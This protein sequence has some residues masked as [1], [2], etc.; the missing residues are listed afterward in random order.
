MSTAHATPGTV[1]SMP[2]KMDCPRRA[3]SKDFSNSLLCIQSATCPTTWT[4]RGDPAVTRQKKHTSSLNTEFPCP[5]MTRATC[6]GFLNDHDCV[7]CAA[8]CLGCRQPL[9]VCSACLFGLTR[10]GRSYSSPATHSEPVLCTA[11]GAFPCPFA[12]P[13]NG[14]F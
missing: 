14:R 1:R 6:V 8:E 7:D 4:T 3:I 10:D 5:Q 12:V 9:A 13:L 2:L 11:A